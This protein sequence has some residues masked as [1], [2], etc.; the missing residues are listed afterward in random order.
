MGKR[1]TETSVLQKMQEI[2]ARLR[3]ARKFWRISQARI[4]AAIGV[5]QSQYSR[6]ELGKEMPD[7]LKLMELA[8]RYRV[9][10]DFICYGLPVRTHPDVFA[11]AV[12]A[13]TE[14]PKVVVKPIGTAGCMDMAPALSRLAP[15]G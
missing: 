2:G 9:S 14:D 7:I 6:W 10:T 12:R 4:G 3:V 13:S 1:P 8:D 15:V 11:A 5:D